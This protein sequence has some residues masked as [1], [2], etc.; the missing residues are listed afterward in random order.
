MEVWLHEFSISALDGDRYLHVSGK[1]APVTAEQEGVAQPPL[2]WTLCGEE[3]SLT[4][5]TARTSFSKSLSAWSNIIQRP[6]SKEYN[7]TVNSIRF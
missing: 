2:V 5:D 1:K 6:L 3:T 7:K 4:G